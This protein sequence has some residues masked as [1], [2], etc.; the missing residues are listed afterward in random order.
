MTKKVGVYG[1]FSH[2]ICQ[3]LGDISNDADW[4]WNPEA[5]YAF[6]CGNWLDGGEMPVLSGQAAW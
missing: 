4:C 3:G 6:A 1:N 5:S 2:P